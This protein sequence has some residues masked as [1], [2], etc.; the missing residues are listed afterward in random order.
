[1]KLPDVISVI[2]FAKPTRENT[3]NFTVKTR[4]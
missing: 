1:M 2:V 4:A 3:L